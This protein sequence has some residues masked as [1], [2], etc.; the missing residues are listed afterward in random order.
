MFLDIYMDNN[1][2]RGRVPF[3]FFTYRFPFLPQSSP[4]FYLYFDFYISH[5]FLLFL[6]FSLFYYLV[7]TCLSQYVPK[8]E[9]NYSCMI[10][11]SAYMSFTS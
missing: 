2:A 8:Q 1:T 6:L 7:H 11:N 4:L 9:P 10:N 5:I 3:Y